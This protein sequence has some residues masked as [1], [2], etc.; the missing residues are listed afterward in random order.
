MNVRLRYS[1]RIQA[2][3]SRVWYALFNPHQYPIWTRVFSVGNIHYDALEKGQK[4]QFLNL[5]GE[6]IWSI[7]DEVEENAKIVFL[8]QGDVVD[9]K[10]KN[11]PSSWKGGKETYELE[12]FGEETILKVTVETIDK[13]ESYFE[14]AF[15]KA[16]ALL[17]ENSESLKIHI[18]ATIEASS[19]RAWEYYNHPEHIVN[20][21]AASDDWHTPKSTNDLRVGGQF[22]HTMAAK[23]GSVGFDFVGM[24]RVVDLHKKIKYSIEDGRMVTVNFDRSENKCHM[25]IDFEPENI[26]PEIFQEQGWQAILNNFKKYIEAS[27]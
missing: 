18:E 15:P 27:N 12:A 21:N 24:Y 3:P 22:C 16:I 4:V 8:H 5:Q 6:G 14:G 19:E 17:K 20:W 9:F 2:K 23:D 11:T 26:H 25:T 10:E 7:I 1:T 13:Y